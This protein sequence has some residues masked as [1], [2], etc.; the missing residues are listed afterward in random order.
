MIYRR[1]K[2]IAIATFL[3]LLLSLQIGCGLGLF[4]T[5]DPVRVGLYTARQ[6]W[7]TGRESAIVA[8]AKNVAPVETCKKY[9]ETDASYTKR[10]NDAVDLY[11]AAKPVTDQA[12]AEI[13]RLSEETKA[14][15]QTINAP[16]AAKK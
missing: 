6:T 13:K 1:V 2:P 8:C 16:A 10:H 12:M 11:L 14:L 15:S 3:A 7:L 4:T 5:N 9:R